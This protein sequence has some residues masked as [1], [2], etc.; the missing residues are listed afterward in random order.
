MSQSS[1]ER[2]D[3]QKQS[4]SRLPNQPDIDR[5]VYSS[6]IFCPHPASFLKKKSSE[7]S[8]E[9]VIS[10]GRNV[11]VRGNTHPPQTLAD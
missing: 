5:I 7:I 3:S 4:F 10:P 2:P 11:E 8:Q 6:Q 1:L 9:I